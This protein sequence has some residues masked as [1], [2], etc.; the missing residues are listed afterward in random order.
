MKIA[1]V[2][3][4]V[5]FLG[6]CLMA[7][8][9]VLNPGFETGS[10]PPWVARA[11]DVSSGVRAHSGTHYTAT[12]CVGPAC[13]TPA[14]GSGAYVYQDLV[15]VVGAQYTLTFYYFPG[16]GTGAA[17]L[18]ALWGPTATQLTTGGAGVC[19]GNCVFDNTQIGTSTYAQ[20]TVANLTA[21]SALTRLEFLGRQDPSEDGLDDVSVIA[22]SLPSTT[23]VPPSVL[24]TMV[25]LACL[26]LSAG[27][28]LRKP[29]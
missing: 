3:G 22:T 24:L 12:G 13:I 23:P 17:E 4:G 5:L 25:G 28:R 14:P 15:T 27:Y 18:Q 20:Y 19:S 2:V 9:I 7:Q 21:T 26:G 8:N 16:P 6:P 10:F 1:R 11:W 29:T